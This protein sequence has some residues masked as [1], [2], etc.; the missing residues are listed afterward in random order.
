MFRAGPGDGQALGR[1][2]KRIRL[3]HGEGAR[4]AGSQEGSCT[5][6][7]LRLSRKRGL[8]GHWGTRMPSACSRAPDECRRNRSAKCKTLRQMEG[9]T[10]HPEKKTLEG[11]AQTQDTRR[12]GLESS[13]SHPRRSIHGTWI[14]RG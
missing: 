10:C 3:I 11:M 6:S 12:M 1:L 9:A 2:E 14:V 5:R 8:L 4:D 13:Y 7:R